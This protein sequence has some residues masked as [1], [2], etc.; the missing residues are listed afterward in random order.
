MDQ[1]QTFLGSCDAFGIGGVLAVDGYVG[2]QADVVRPFEH[3][4]A[5]VFYGGAIDRNHATRHEW[6]KA[7]PFRLPIAEVL[8]PQEGTTGMRILQHQLVMPVVDLTIKHLFE[9]I[10]DPPAS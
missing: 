5:A 1:W 8:M 6:E 4:K 2:D 10:D 7:I 3:L 9:R